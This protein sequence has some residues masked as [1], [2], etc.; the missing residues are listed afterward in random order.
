MFYKLIGIALII[1]AFVVEISWIALCFGSVI[2]GIVLLIF[3][4]GIL[5]V[6]FN[7]LFGLGLAFFAKGSLSGFDSHSYK[8]HEYRY[9]YRNGSHDDSSY[10]Q[11]STIHREPDAGMQHY[12]DILG[13]SMDDD[14]ETIRNAYRK[15]SREYHPDAI[16]GKG[17]GP[18]FVELAT[19]KMQEINE[20]Y[21]KIKEARGR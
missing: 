14:F 15:L 3:A 7:I 8:S 20:A 6:P 16:A 11:D 17:L 19:R 1:A 5:I 10:R 2:V 4:P 12:Y 13:C 18:D 21:E 9:G